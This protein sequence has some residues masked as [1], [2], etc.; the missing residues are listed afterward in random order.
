M[1]GLRHVGGDAGQSQRSLCLCAAPSGSRCRGWVALLTRVQASAAATRPR[2]G[3]RRLAKPLQADGFAGGRD[4]ARRLMRQAKVTVRRP[5]PRH[6]VTPDSRH[7]S[8]VAPHLLARHLAVE[9]PD[10]VGVG[11]IT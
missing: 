4:Q 8:R 10:Q 1:V 9:K 5:K 3:S 7:G 2:Y 6:P 11:E